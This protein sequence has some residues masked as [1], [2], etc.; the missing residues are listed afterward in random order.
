MATVTGLTAARMLII[1]AA[2]VIA[3]IVTGDNLILTKRD[4]T[5]INAGNV[6][7]PQGS[8][9][10]PGSITVSPAGGDLSGNYPN[11]AIAAG[12]VT[13]A[14]VSATNKD[15]TAVTSSMR[16]L[17]TGQQQAAAGDHLHPVSFVKRTTDQVVTAEQRITNVAYDAVIGGVYEVF[18]QLSVKSDAIGSFTTAILREDSIGT[19]LTGTQIQMAIKDH[20][21]ANRQ[22]VLSLMSIFTAEASGT[23]HI[24]L[25]LNSSGGSSATSVALVDQPTILRVVR[26]A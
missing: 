15:G 20:R 7:G 26:I 23:R 3:G 1:E 19:G 13:D 5:T 9:G 2:S 25:F 11:P 22:E 4:G 8:Q 12:V 18:A 6:R 21:L 10:V 16:T 24:K 14:K 17:G